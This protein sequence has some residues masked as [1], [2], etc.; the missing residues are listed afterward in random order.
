MNAETDGDLYRS[1]PDMMRLPSGEDRVLFC[2]LWPRS[3][4]LLSGMSQRL[5]QG[6]ESFATL[7]DHSARLCRELNLMPLQ[8]ESLRR[9]LGEL[10]AAGLLVSRR[11]MLAA[12]APPGRAAEPPAR[13]ATVGVPTRD[14]PRDL[15]RCLVGHTESARRHGR[16]TEFVVMD[17]S[18]KAARENRGMLDALAEDTGLPIF[19]AG[20]DHKARFAAALARQAGVLPELVRFALGIEEDW[21]IATGG[22]RN[23]LLLETAG[24]L[25]LQVD[26]DTHC[27][28]FPAPES[29]GGLVL[30]AA[31]D[32]TQFWFF[33]G[34]VT[35]PPPDAP[36]DTDLLAMHERLLGRTVA[37]CLDGGPPPDLTANARF[38]RR[39]TSG[40]GRILTTT[41]GVAG[42]SGM[43]SCL[44]LLM[45]EG[46]SRARLL[47]TEAGFRA[48]LVRRQ[49]M[50]AATRTTV[51][52][53]GMCMALN[54][55][56]D[57]RRVL[58]P[59]LPYQRNQDG[60]FGAVLALCGGGF[61]GFL[62]WMVPH[63][64]GTR[65]GPAP[66]VSW[67]RTVRLQTG[68]LMQVLLGSFPQGPGRTTPEALLGRVG[69]WLQETG[70]ADPADFA[71]YVRLHGWNALTRT[72]GRLEASLRQH[73][74]RPAYWA[75]DVGRALAALT[76]ALT[77]PEAGLP[78]DLCEKWGPEQALV[79]FQGLVRRYGA[80]LRA[81]PRLV[82][83][84]KA[85]RAGGVRLA[86]RCGKPV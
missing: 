9:E 19:Y 85:L 31:F 12:V 1:F 70:S 48:A 59:F 5:L 26:D 62:P 41:T 57:N 80:L 17:D 71:E 25:M 20:P 29:S 61:N 44:A 47:Q 69:K 64:S 68:H 28:A 52:D 33:P 55:G 75:E 65:A 66:E 53:G 39:L 36:G 13:I 30:S 60:V 8:V 72:A 77:G 45:L 49:S 51:T 56:L 7:D 38:F 14:R 86:S 82:E 46:A 81:W 22:S 54:L 27:H 76:E 4:R 23:A 37:D 15:E 35:F 40:E 2:S 84:A 74:G 16:R 43:G 34:E 83:S 18:A 78:A 42:N 63:D 32:P 73:G 24:N 79:R 50:R 10:A 58:P 11:Q 21:P 6:C 3:S 67:A